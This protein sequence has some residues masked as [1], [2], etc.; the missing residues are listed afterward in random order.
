[1]S[2][3]AERRL[4]VGAPLRCAG[5]EVYNDAAHEDVDH[6][7][8]LTRMSAI[9]T[10][11]VSILYVN[12]IGR[13][14]PEQSF[15]AMREWKRIVKPTGVLMLT[16]IDAQAVANAMLGPYEDQVQ[17]TLLQARQSSH[18]T[19]ELLSGALQLAGFSNVRRVESFNLFLDVSGLKLNDR[20]LALNVIANS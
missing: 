13:L 7:G 17:L 16:G 20:S 9:Q 14:P 19:A 18:W 12:C 15:W 2:G 5:W 3:P 1:M 4:Y 10:G 11:S 6:V 8:S